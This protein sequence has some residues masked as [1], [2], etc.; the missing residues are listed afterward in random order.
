MVD[1]P[2]IWFG[3]VLTKPNQTKLIFESEKLVKLPDLNEISIAL[4][5]IARQTVSICL[6]TF[7]EKTECTSYSVKNKSV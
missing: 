6:R 4:K 2:L 7:P 3:L 5:P 1:M